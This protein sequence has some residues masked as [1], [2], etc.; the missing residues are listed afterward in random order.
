MCDSVLAQLD[1]VDPDGPWEPQARRLAEQL[2][3]RLLARPALLPALA[4]GPVTQASLDT[5]RDLLALLV[6]A[7]MPDALA[8]G[9]LNAVL[10]YVLGYAEL[11]AAGPLAVPPQTRTAPGDPALALLTEPADFDLGL[12]LLLDGVRA[13]LP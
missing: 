4:C 13:R 7:G 3:D 11:H 5:G 2:R 10:A 9:T 1:A 12:D 8:V 6:R